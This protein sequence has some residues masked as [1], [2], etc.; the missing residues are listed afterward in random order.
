MISKFNL[1]FHEAYLKTKPKTEVKLHLDKYDLV[2]VIDVIEDYDN[3]IRI[4][5]Y[6][7]TSKFEINKEHRLQLG[8]N[9]YLYEEEYG[10]K[11]DKVGVYFLK[12][13]LHLISVDPVL[14]NFAK[15]KS[16]EVFNKTKSNE[17][18]NYPQ[19]TGYL[20]KRLG[21]MCPCHRY[22]EDP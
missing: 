17:I 12:E 21:D 1:P 20:C 11:P 6:K 16:I 19:N 3:E 22:E 14:I 4:I 7:T 13:K 2:C 8:I 18:K 9:A 10:V 15:N 5:D